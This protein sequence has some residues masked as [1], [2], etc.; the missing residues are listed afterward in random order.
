M[1][2]PKKTKYRYPHIVKYEGLAKGYKELT[3]GQFGLQAQEGSYITTNQI[4]AARKVISKFVK[5]IGKMRI[6]VFP[7]L[8]KTKK[9]LEVRM[10]SGKGSVDGWVAVAKVG[11]VMF[12]L[13]DL[14]KNIAYEALTAASYKLPIRCRVIE[15]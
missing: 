10:G 14:P 3:W 2:I 4:E 11:T 9:P 12:E 1:R 8:A 6:N 7:H 15:R 5:K 13:S